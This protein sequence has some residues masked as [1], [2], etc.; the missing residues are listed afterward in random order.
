MSSHDDD[1]SAMT[2]TERQYLEYILAIWQCFQEYYMW[3]CVLFFF[4]IAFFQ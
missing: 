1:L 3:P 2:K 4:L